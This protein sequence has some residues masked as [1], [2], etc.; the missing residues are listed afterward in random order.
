MLIS[1]KLDSWHFCDKIISNRIHVFFTSYIQ[2]I[3]YLHSMF[4]LFPKPKDEYQQRYDLH[5]VGVICNL[6]HF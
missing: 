3:H 4:S 2:I 6:V 5:V 1:S